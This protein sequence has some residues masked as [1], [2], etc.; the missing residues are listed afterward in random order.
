MTMKRTI[1]FVSDGTGITA[2]TLGLSLLSQ[3][4]NINFEK[5]TILYVNT[6]EKAQEVIK[7]INNVSEREKIKPVVFATLVDHSIHDL[8]KTSN[9]V[10]LDFIST[11]IEPLEKALG[12]Q[13]S[14]T[15]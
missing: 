11:F 2:E 7:E 8:I 6:I 13:S 3:F 5:N 1:F 9:A 15:M 14:H 12:C 10:F 4:E